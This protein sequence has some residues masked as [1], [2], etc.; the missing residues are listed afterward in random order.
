[1]LHLIF[2]AIYETAEYPHYPEVRI[3]Q[4]LF[5]ARARLKYRELHAKTKIPNN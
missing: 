4:V 1:M 2:T 5:H 3:S